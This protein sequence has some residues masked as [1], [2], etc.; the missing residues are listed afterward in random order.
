MLA[1]IKEDS[2]Y[3]QQACHNLG[4][5]C[6]AKPSS[7]L[8]PCRPDVCMPASPKNIRAYVFCGMCR[9]T[10]GEDMPAVRAPGYA[11]AFMRLL[12]REG[13][14]VFTNGGLFVRA[15]S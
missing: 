15:I 11:R 6:H 9:S 7:Q 2:I 12:R 13:G 5:E 4:L 1:S 14:V 10:F 3:T 8:G